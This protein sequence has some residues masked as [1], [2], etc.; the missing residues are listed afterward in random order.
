MDG[1]NVKCVLFL[2]ITSFL[3][4]H[5]IPQPVY[6]VWGHGTGG[7]QGGYC[8]S[9]YLLVIQDASHQTTS[10]FFSHHNS[11]SN[12]SQR[13]QHNTP[14]FFTN[15]STSIPL[16]KSKLYPQFWS[17]NTQK[18]AITCFGA[19]LY[20]MVTQHRNLHQLSIP[21]SRVTYFIQRANTG[22]SVS[23][24]QLRKNLGKVLEKMRINGLGG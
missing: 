13:N 24:S 9:V 7:A 6:K 16:G 15:H 20:S 1:M 3:Y 18:K 4:I 8:R 14:T 17:A 19:Y 22:T 21:M 10:L 23:H 11:P 5:C 12:I 2:K